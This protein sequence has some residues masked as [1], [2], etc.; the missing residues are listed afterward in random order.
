VVDA[1]KGLEAREFSTFTFSQ[2]E[3]KLRFLTERRSKLK[4]KIKNFIKVVR[5]AQ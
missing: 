5:T 4:S 3:K 2:W 1:G